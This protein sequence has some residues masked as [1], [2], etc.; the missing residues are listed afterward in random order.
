MRFSVRNGDFL[1]CSVF[2]TISHETPTMR[3]EQLPF[4]SS[5]ISVESLVARQEV[6]DAGR[7]LFDPRHELG[8]DFCLPKNDGM[9]RRQVVGKFD[10]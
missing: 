6:L 9:A 10:G 3:T 1:F 8:N 5:Q 4:H 7:L 2:S